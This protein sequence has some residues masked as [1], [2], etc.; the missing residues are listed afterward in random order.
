[1]PACPPARLSADLHVC[2]PVRPYVFPHVYCLLAGHHHHRHD[3]HRHHQIIM[4]MILMILI[5]IIIMFIGMM[6]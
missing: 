5:V 1:V 3:H 4:I 6:S 2:L